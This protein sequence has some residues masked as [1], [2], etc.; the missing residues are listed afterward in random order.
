M[1]YVCLLVCVRVGMCVL[2]C[3]QLVGTCRCVYV[4]VRSCWP[5]CVLVCV[6]AVE[7]RDPLLFLCAAHFGFLIYFHFNVYERLCACMCTVCVR[8]LRRPEES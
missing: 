3:E 1:L 4:G 2:A 7:A 8:C 6:H 5:V